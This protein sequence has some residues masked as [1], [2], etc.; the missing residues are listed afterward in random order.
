MAIDLIWPGMLS[1]YFVD[2]KALYFVNVSLPSQ[3]P[4]ITAASP[5]I[6]KLV[7][8]A[9]RADIGLCIYRTDLLRQYGYREPPRTWVRAGGL[10]RLEFRSWRTSKGKKQFWG[11]VWSGGRLTRL[12]TCDALE[13]QAAEGGGRIIEEDQT[14]SVNNPQA[15]R[16]WQRAAR[17]VG[18]ISPPSVVWIQRVGFAETFGSQA[19]R[20]FMR[21]WPSAYVDSQAV[22]VA[23]SR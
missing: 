13:W 16:A 22:R 3:F 8:M 12:L 19:T 20:T 4:P 9:Y 17:W 6:Y 15:I 1:E 2:L 18:S 21:N 7:A 11:F 14:I 23:N 10:W 5:S